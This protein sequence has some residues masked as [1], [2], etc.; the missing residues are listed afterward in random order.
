[1]KSRKTQKKAEN[2][3]KNTGVL[4]F[5]EMKTYLLYLRISQKGIGR[6]F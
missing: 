3:R 1:M 5:S 6:D 2:A 4:S